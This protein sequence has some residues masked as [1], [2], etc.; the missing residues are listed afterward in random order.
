M[1]RMVLTRC[2]SLPSSD[3]MR[4][5]SRGGGT[6]EAGGT[7]T[8]SLVYRVSTHQIR[9]GR[10]TDRSSTSQGSAETLCA[11]NKGANREVS[12]GECFNDWEGGD[13]TIPSPGKLP[14]QALPGMGLHNLIHGRQA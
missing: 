2:A 13:T 5:S 12:K 9:R 14:K 8:K 4:L 10:R 6:R 1:L 7:V 3:L 11:R